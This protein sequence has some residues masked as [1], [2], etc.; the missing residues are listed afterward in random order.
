MPDKE[1]T[2]AQA[3]RASITQVARE[4]GVSHQ[5]VSRV[6]NHSPNVSAATRDRVQAVIQRLNYR[7]SASARALVTQH[8]KTIG[9]I[10]GGVEYYGP[11]ST[12]TAIES[13]AREHGFYLSVAILDEHE[14]TR[15]SFEDVANSFL[16]QG[17]EAFIFLAPTQNM[18]DAAVEAAIDR[19]RIVLTSAPLETADDSLRFLGIDQEA[20]AHDV[21][22]YLESLGHRRVVFFSGPHDWPDAHVRMTAWIHASRSLGWDSRVI[23]LK[24]WD[25]QEAFDR[26]L[27]EFAGRAARDLPTAI[28]TSNDLQAIGVCKALAE[29]DIAVPQ[30]VS[31]TG[32][33]DMPGSGFLT[34]S[35]T[36]VR[37]DFTAL[38]QRAME[39]LL[40]LMGVQPA[41]HHPARVSAELVIR[42]STAE[43]RL[44]TG[45]SA[46]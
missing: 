2:S 23:S 19:P 6:I 38:G 12:M 10:A 39:E 30:Q 26:T 3:H 5:T 29:L 46:L 33:D 8:T 9:F 16:D 37:P 25:A 22:R 24:T 44:R 13:V 28:V 15:A 31:V 36:T 20:A 45:G 32:F 35:L 18:V 34:P 42:G 40:D 7:P 1:S 21:A 41:P 17:V 14:Y 4:A 11:T 27:S 43:P